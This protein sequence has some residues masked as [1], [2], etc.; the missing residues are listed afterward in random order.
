MF[1][2]LGPLLSRRARAHWKSLASLKRRRT[3][4]HFA[5]GYGSFDERFVRDIKGRDAFSR[6]LLA[7]LR[8]LGAPD[9]CTVIWGRREPWDAAL[10]PTLKNLVIGRFGQEDVILVCRPG[11]LAYLH[12]HDHVYQVIYRPS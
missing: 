10:E 4:L 3:N 6:P 7:E 2:L 5:V 12:T 1:A 8:R 11:R 9:T